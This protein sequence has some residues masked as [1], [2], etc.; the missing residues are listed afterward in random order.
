MA[1][2]LLLMAVSDGWTQPVETPVKSPGAPTGS[3][4]FPDAGPVLVEKASLR[5]L[6]EALERKDI[7]TAGPMIWQLLAAI[8]K[9]RGQGIGPSEFLAAGYRA[10]RLKGTDA[11]TVQNC[12]LSAWGAAQSLALLTPENLALMERGSAPLATRGL[13]R[14]KVVNFETENL[15]AITLTTKAVPRKAAP[16]PEPVPLPVKDLPP[17]QPAFVL[18]TLE[19]RLHERVPLDAYGMRN[20]TFRVDS[21]D[22][23]GSVSYFLEDRTG[24]H[25][26]LGDRV[27]TLDRLGKGIGLA[28]QIDR[29]RPFAPEV[30]PD[31]TTRGVKLVTFPFAAIY[32]D[33]DVGTQEPLRLVIRVASEAL[34]LD[35]LPPER[36]KLYEIASPPP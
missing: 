33:E 30:I 34:M 10:E 15:P 1:V 16:A 7:D 4:L 31:T 22:P 27:G 23:R 18:K 24:R 13:E 32:L 35:Q 5:G 26:G 6:L 36:R 11:G 14:G 2:A 17:A 9:S 21:V 29:M 25:F 3:G 12:L 28:D 8:S 20:V 19:I